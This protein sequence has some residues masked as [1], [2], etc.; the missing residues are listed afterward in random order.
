MTDSIFVEWYK[1]S[2]KYFKIRINEV[3]EYIN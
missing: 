2:N 3:Q 1:L